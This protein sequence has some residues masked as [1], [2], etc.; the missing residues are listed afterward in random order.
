M[1]ILTVLRQRCHRY[2]HFNEFLAQEVWLSYS[3]DFVQKD[4]IMV[5]LDEDGE[6]IYMIDKESIS[7]P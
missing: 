3:L 7:F 2:L 5:E 1:G 6:S 4:A